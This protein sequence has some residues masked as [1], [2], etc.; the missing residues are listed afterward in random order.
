MQKLAEVAPRLLAMVHGEKLEGASFDRETLETIQLLGQDLLH[1]K[2]K[3]HQARSLK[4]V[5]ELPEEDLDLARAI[6]LIQIGEDPERWPELLS[7][8][9][10]MDFMALQVRARAG[11]AHDPQALIHAI[12]H[13]LFHEL[14]FRFPPHSLYR[15]NVDTYTLL[16]AVLDS[17]RGVCLGVST[18]YLCLAQR[19]GLRMQVVTPPGHIYVRYHDAQQEINIETTARGIHLPDTRYLGINTRSLHLRSYRDV[20]GLS[21]INQAAPLWSSGDYAQL[22]DLYT[23]AQ[24][25][26]PD[27]LN[28]KELL[29]LARFAAGDSKSAGTELHALKGRIADDAVNGNTSIGDLVAGQADTYAIQA[30]MRP[31]DQD[32]A[33]ILA[34]QE[35]LR[36]ILARFPACRSAWFQ[37]AISYLNLH[38]YKEAQEALEAFHAIDAGDATVE[39]LL[40]QLNV[41][42]YRYPEA[43]VHFRRA[44]DITQARD[45]QPEC[46]QE[47][48]LEL[49]RRAPRREFPGSL[50]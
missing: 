22:I 50:N 3:G 11:S 21:L 15:E 45:C 8:E 35:T 40:A 13:L 17:R 12:N 30:L 46:L 43:W 5:E 27:D 49:M 32:R 42:R 26:L 37:L 41:D 2:L 9:A 31:M 10:V 24:S 16:P 1:H 33:S 14:R 6:L 44:W 4:D 36:E 38:R 34:R 20:I 7:Y 39:Y 18:L 47:L 19:L 28:L 29:L 25:I 48:G 23:R